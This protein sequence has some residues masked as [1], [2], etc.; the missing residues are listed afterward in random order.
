MTPE[1]HCHGT[2][3]CWQC[4]N[5]RASHLATRDGEPGPHCDENC[6]TE[7]EEQQA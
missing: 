1:Q 4:F 7:D 3:C 5:G 6:P 2:D